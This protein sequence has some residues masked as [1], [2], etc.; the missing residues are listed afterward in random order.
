MMLPWPWRRKYWA[1]AR[2]QYQR[3]VRSVSTIWQN[4]SL[5]ECSARQALRSEMPALLMSTSTVPNSSQAAFMRF[6]TCS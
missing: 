1:E 3:P 6:S 2:Q 4:M 5:S